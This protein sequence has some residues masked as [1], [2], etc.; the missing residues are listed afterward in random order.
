MGRL[1]GKV[2]IVFGASPN[3]GGTIAHWLAKEG[4][5]IAACDLDL[6]LIHI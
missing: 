2:A 3:M 5:K 1:D 4:A 6:S